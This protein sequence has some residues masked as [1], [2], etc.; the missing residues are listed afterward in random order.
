MLRALAASG[1]V[2]QM[3]ILSSYVKTPLPNPVRDSAQQALRKKY[4]GFKNLTEEEMTKA[5]HEWYETD[6]KYPQVL[7]T[8]S[9]V[10]D[11]IDHIVNIAGIRHVGIGTDFD[12]GGAVSGCEDVSEMGN[13]TIELLRRGYKSREI[14]LIWGKNLLRVMKEVEKY[15]KKHS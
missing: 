5:R 3:C 15:A 10:V 12:G 13:I 11:H 8:V 2:I 1:G 7:A 4:N 14:R 9:D 6:E